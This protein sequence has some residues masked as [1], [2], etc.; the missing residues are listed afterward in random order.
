MPEHGKGLLGPYDVDK[1][2]E[3]LPYEHWVVS[4]D[5]RRVDDVLENLYMCIGDLEYFDT[6]NFDGRLGKGASKLRTFNTFLAEGR[7]AGSGWQHHNPTTTKHWICSSSNSI[8][9]L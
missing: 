7:L 9:D 6:S 4:F 5:P 1:L 2:V 3:L 8:F